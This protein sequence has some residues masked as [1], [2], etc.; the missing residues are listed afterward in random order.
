MALYVKKKPYPQYLNNI[1][2]YSLIKII[3]IHQLNLLNM[4]WET[5]ISHEMFKGP[6]IFSSVHHEEGGPSSHEKV[7]KTETVGVPVF[8][9][10]KRG[11]RKLF[12]VAR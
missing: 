5:F 6:Q 2:H 12:A 7:K 8:V 1:F 3:V 9:T 11:T 10:Y 4:P